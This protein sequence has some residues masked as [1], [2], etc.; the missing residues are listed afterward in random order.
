MTSIPQI[1]HHYNH[2]GG[3]FILPN[4]HF[5]RIKPFPTMTHSPHIRMT[6]FFFFFLLRRCN[7][8]V[9]K[10]KS[11]Q[12]HTCTMF[13]PQSAACCFFSCVCLHMYEHARSNCS[14]DGGAEPRPPR[15]PQLLHKYPFDGNCCQA[16]SWSTALV[17]ARL[18]R[19]WIRTSSR[20]CF[21]FFV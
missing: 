17:S 4:C 16:P 13:T 8:A 7:L 6:F 21:L 3:I 12:V 5:G 20:P 19:C 10:C 15:L 9:Q 18:D 1:H 14:E 2:I 11:L